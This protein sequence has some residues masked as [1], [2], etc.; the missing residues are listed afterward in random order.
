MYAGEGMCEPKTKKNGHLDYPISKR[1]GNMY[2]NRKH[3]IPRSVRR[4][5]FPKRFTGFLAINLNLC[6]RRRPVI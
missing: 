1:P 6:Q 3:L 2:S 4:E 5:G